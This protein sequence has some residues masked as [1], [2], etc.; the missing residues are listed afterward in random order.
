VLPLGALLFAHAFFGLRH[1]IQSA[2]E[3]TAASMLGMIP[4]GLMLLTSVSL[5]V[6]V[7]ALAKRNTLVQELYCIETLSRV[8]MLCLDKTGT[9]TTGNMRV[10][11]IYAAD[12]GR[13]AEIEAGLSDLVQTIPADNATARA[14]RARFSGPARQTP[15]FVTPFSSARRYSAAAF[16]SG[17][18]ISARCRR[19]GQTC[20]K[21][22][23]FRRT[24]GNRGVPRTALCGVRHGK[25]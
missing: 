14:L 5:A 8:D 22:C 16:A 23:A 2:V 3:Q 11:E 15:L 25:R 17:H 24:G 19:C 13:E 7:I 20:R 21:H 18:I 4:S 9:L 10:A 1:P 6:G 12:A